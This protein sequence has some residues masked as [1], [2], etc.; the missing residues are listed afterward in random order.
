ME[1]DGGATV[2]VGLAAT[3]VA[4]TVVAAMAVAVMVNMVVMVAE[5]VARLLKCQALLY[6]KH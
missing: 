4:A 5:A 3:V 6:T 2:A 1:G